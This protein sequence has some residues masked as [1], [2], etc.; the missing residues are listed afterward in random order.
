MLPPTILS[1]HERLSMLAACS[2]CSSTLIIAAVRSSETAVSFYQP[3][4]RHLP[5]NKNHQLQRLISVSPIG[6]LKSYAELDNKHIL[7]CV[8]S[9]D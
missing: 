8:F 7:G 6:M 9:R 5:E 1:F 3:M 4:R 2:A